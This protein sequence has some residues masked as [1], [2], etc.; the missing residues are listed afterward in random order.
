MKINRNFSGVVSCFIFF[1]ASIPSQLSARMVVIA[2]P[3]LPPM[4]NSAGNG[5]EAS[6]ITETLA[7]CGHQVHFKLVPFGRHW[8]EYGEKGDLDAVATV[9]SDM[10]M[11]GARSVPYIRYQNGASVLKSSGLTIKTLGDLTG[12][13]VVT[14]FGASGVLPGLKDAA[15]SFAEFRERADQLSHSNLL[16]AGRVEAVLSDGLIFA[17]YNRQLIEKVKGGESLSFDPKQ[18]VV[19]TAIFPPNEYTMMFRDESL[20]DDF[21][22]CYD[23]LVKSGRADAIDRDVIGQYSATVGSQYLSRP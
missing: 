10:A 14:F 5:R 20:R 23:G 6:V 16:F 1:L 18:D 21:N 19:F 7:S 2:A 8:I 15:S 13:R 17:E 12:K 4:F 22:R 9:P 11:T 3:E